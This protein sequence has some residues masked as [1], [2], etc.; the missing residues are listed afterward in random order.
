MYL[1]EVDMKKR[2][3]I[4]R[5][6]NGNR[7]FIIW[8][9]VENGYITDAFGNNCSYEDYEDAKEV[10]EELNAWCETVRERNM[11]VLISDNSCTAP[12]VRGYFNTIADAK[13]YALNENL[14][15][16]AIYLLASDINFANY[17]CVED[18]K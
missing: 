12:V 5:R 3:E 2:F 18:Y 10:C 6:D 11:Y 14:Q 17:K 8:D 15:D 4:V 1:L 13:E 9:N 7:Y 16:I